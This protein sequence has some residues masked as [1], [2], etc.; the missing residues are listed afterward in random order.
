MH[1]YGGGEYLIHKGDAFFSNFTDQQLYYQ[2]AGGAPGRITTDSAG[3]A[4]RYADSVFDEER[5]RLISFRE[6]KA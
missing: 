2:R 6:L 1:E 4:L 5:N 3:D